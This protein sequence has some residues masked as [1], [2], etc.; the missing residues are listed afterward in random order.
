MAESHFQRVTRQG[1]EG[2]INHDYEAGDMHQV[3]ERL[4]VWPYGRRR[5]DV[6]LEVA[7]YA[8]R[9]YGA[10]QPTEEMPVVTLEMLEKAA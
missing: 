8:V 1:I 2:N 10:D 5:P 9:R 6:S 4:D 7:R 3:D